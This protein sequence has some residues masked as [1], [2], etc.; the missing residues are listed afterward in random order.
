MGIKYQREVR[1]KMGGQ[2]L[3]ECVGECEE[4]VCVRDEE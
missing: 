1:G 3:C 2:I 4:C